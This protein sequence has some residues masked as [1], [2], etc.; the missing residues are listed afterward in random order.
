M[1][2]NAECVKRCLRDGDN[3]VLV[4]EEGKVLKILNPDKVYSDFYGQKVTAIGKA[5]GERITIE[6]LK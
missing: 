6:S 1:W 5:E 2:A 4:T 3:P